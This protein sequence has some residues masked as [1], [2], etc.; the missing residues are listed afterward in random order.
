MPAR[1]D[2]HSLQKQRNHLTMAKIIGATN[3]QKTIMLALAEGW[4]L[5]LADRH[6]WCLFQPG[7]ERPFSQVARSTVEKMTQNG[8][9]TA[10]IATKELNFRPEKLLTTSGRRYA[11]K[12]IDTRWAENYQWDPYRTAGSIDPNSS[13][14]DQLAA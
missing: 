6:G 11:R 2:L 3:T 5:R 1:S 9:L 4:R 7:R 10:G 14:A 12:L 13:C 8:W